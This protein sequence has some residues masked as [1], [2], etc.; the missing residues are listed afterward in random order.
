MIVGL[1]LYVQ[2]REIARNKARSK[3][4]PEEAT[5]AEVYNLLASL[6]RK[7]KNFKIKRLFFKTMF[8]FQISI[9]V[10]NTK[11]LDLKVKTR[12]IYYRA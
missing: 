8:W 9:H 7:M 12:A 6:T 1:D 11:F 5:M 2:H 4:I 10:N 3:I